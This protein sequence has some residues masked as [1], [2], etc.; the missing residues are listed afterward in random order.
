M[1]PVLTALA[2]MWL[3]W[4]IGKE[5]RERHDA[6]TIDQEQRQTRA[7]VGFIPQH[8]PGVSVGDWS[9]E[10]QVDPAY[11]A[12]EAIRPSLGHG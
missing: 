10:A 12:L 6:K 4:L 1:I 5:V 7:V 9:D 8:S 11:D 3:A 2:A